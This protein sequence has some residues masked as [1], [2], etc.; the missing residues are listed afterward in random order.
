MSFLWRSDVSS[1][2]CKLCV[3]KDKRINDYELFFNETKDVLRTKDERNAA[4]Q[5]E[6]SEK[7]SEVELLKKSYEVEK[8]QWLEDKKLWTEV[9]KKY[10]AE[11]VE[12]E[13]EIER[14]EGLLEDNNNKMMM[15]NKYQKSLEEKIT[16]LVHSLKQSDAKYQELLEK[17]TEQNII[18]S[19]EIREREE[20]IIAVYEKKMDEMR[21]DFEE[22]K[23]IWFERES[24]LDVEISGLQEMNSNLQME[25][26]D[27]K[28]DLQVLKETHEKEL[29]TQEEKWEKRIESLNESFDSDFV[30]YKLHF[31]E[32]EDMIQ[33]DVENLQSEIDRLKKENEWLEQSKN[34]NEKK[35]AEIE[36]QNKSLKDEYY[37]EQYRN[38]LLQNEL[39][40]NKKTIEN[41][42]KDTNAPI[43]NLE[44]QKTTKMYFS[45]DH[46]IP[47]STL[48]ES[49]EHV[50]DNQRKKKRHTKRRNVAVQVQNGYSSFYPSYAETQMTETG[51]EKKNT[52]FVMDKNEECPQVEIDI[53]EESSC[54]SN[55]FLSSD[56]STQPWITFEKCAKEIEQL[57]IQNQDLHNK[58]KLYE[59][60]S[61]LQFNRNLRSGIPV[62]FFPYHSNSHP[63]SDS[64]FH[65]GSSSLN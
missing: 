16:N 38:Q 10:Q 57:K 41:H 18:Q 43:V 29:A 62:R 50:Q 35:I 48:I 6:L 33:K 5:I 31:K 22:E 65:G 36:L 21:D 24:D 54:D 14:F 37:D 45:Q 26:Q 1:N 64:V 63:L 61:I 23:Q 17:V 27:I 15:S 2:L 3:D 52:V 30:S 4:L 34:V 53:H 55:F 44:S 20:D 8:R 39:Q 19:D 12:L 46:S 25:I 49:Q 51:N 28:Y 56:T 47:D 40:A 32:K 13:S 58:I 9:A 60:N 42:L 11:L 59:C 7:I